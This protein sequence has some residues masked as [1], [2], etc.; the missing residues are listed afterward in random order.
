MTS[1]VIIIMKILIDGRVYHNPISAQPSQTAVGGG[2]HV[3]S[4]AGPVRMP[5][6]ENRV[7]QDCSFFSLGEDSR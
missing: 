4:R 7:R 3:N 6:I 5:R 2:P 1:K